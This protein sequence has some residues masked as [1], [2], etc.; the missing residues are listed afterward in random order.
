[1]YSDLSSFSSR[2]IDR[3]TL[4]CC[5][6]ENEALIFVLVQHLRL[7]Q[8]RLGNSR[9]VRFLISR[10]HWSFLI[11]FRFSGW[12]HWTFSLRYFPLKK[13]VT[14][15]LHRA[16]LCLYVVSSLKTTHSLTNMLPCDSNTSDW[17]VSA[18]IHGLEFKFTSAHCWQNNNG[19]PGGDIFT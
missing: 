7:C 11:R 5:G 10:D 15:C 12:K 14:K 6:K 4:N 19:K 3:R 16:Q 13:Y 17:V 1:M 2:T 9:T 18:L 8:N